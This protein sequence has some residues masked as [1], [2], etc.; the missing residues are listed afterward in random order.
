MSAYGGKADSNHHIALQQ[1]MTRSRH[2]PCASDLSPLSGCRPRILRAAMLVFA[3]TTRLKP[4]V[5]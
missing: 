4:H 1:L 5:F 2:Q 3:T